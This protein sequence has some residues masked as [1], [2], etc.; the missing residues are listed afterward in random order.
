MKRKNRITIKYIKN[1][2]VERLPFL[3]YFYAVMQDNFISFLKST[4]NWQVKAR[5]NDKKLC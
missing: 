5:K 2:E 3:Y 4:E 1:K